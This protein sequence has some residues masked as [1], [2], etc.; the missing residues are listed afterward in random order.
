MTGP[1]FNFVHLLLTGSYTSGMGMKVAFVTSEPAVTSTRPSGSV[2][3]VG[4]QRAYAMS[5]PRVQVM[6]AGLKKFVI[7]NPTPGPSQSWPPT[8]ITRPSA[9]TTWP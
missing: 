8:N 5:G 7:L 4:Y 3:T 9:R 2:V 6:V 1:E